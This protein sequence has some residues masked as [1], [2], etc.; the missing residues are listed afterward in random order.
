MIHDGLDRSVDNS[1]SVH[2]DLDV[3]ATAKSFIFRSV[4]RFWLAF[5]SLPFFSCLVQ[6]NHEHFPK[7]LAWIR[8]RRDHMLSCLPERP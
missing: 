5:S 4:C 7:W 3:V 2:V 6:L 1:A 8:F